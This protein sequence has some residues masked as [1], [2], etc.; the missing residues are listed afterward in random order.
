MKQQINEIKRMQQLAGILNE[1]QLNELDSNLENIKNW[2]VKTATEINFTSV[3]GEH[4]DI[5][6]IIL[7]NPSE[8]GYVALA[9]DKLGDSRL[10]T[11]PLT[12]DNAIKKDEKAFTEWFKQKFR[13]NNNIQLAKSNTRSG[14]LT[15]AAIESPSDKPILQWEKGMVKDI[16]NQNT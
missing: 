15:K 7:Y 12:L 9:T 14:F 11:S 1:N 2:K 13:I 8:Y 16:T 3:G 5:N 4:G 10:F 6:W